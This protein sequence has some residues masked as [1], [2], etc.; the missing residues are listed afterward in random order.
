MG[1]DILRPGDAT[2]SMDDDSVNNTLYDT[3]AA[4][5]EEIPAEAF[6]EALVSLP[7]L[8]EVAA[9]GATAGV[10][11]DAEVDGSGEVAGADTDGADGGVT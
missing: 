3:Q 6:T 10:G 4:E 2:K 8:L 11:V 5:K 7:S 1:I 9:V